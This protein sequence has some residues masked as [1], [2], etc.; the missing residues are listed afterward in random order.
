MSWWKIGLTDSPKPSIKSLPSTLFAL[1]PNWP[2]GIPRNWGGCNE[3]CDGYSEGHSVLMMKLKEHLT[4]H[5]W[6]PMR[7]QGKQWSHRKKISVITASSRPG[8]LFRTIWSFIVSKPNNKKIACKLW[9]IC[10]LFC[11]QGLV[12]LLGHPSHNWYRSELIAP[13]L[14]SGLVLDCFNCFFQELWSLPFISL[15]HVHLGWLRLAMM[16]F[17]HPWEMS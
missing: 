8:Q 16:A 3:S 15:I 11:R 10:E 7:W 2:H 1:V 9:V 17:R 14:S 4:E 12:T 13:C 6:K 5:L